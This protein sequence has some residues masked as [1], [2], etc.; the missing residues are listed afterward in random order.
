[1]TKKEMSWHSLALKDM[2]EKLDTDFKKGL[3]QTD[4]EGRLKKHGKNVFEQ[5]EKFYYWKLLWRQIRSPLVFILIIAGFV[6][7]FL[8]EITNTVVIFL[9]IFINVAIGIFQEGKASKA[10]EKIKGSQRKTTTVI[11]DGSQKIIEA[12]EVVPGDIIVLRMGDQ[13]PADARLLEDKGLEINESIITGEWAAVSK[14]SKKKA[15]EDARITKRENMVWMGTLVTEGW[16][17]AIVVETG[18]STEMG[19]IA[20]LVSGK[21]RPLTPL[22]K[23]IK[24]LAQFL[25]IVILATLA[26][27]FVLGILRGTPLSEM[28]LLSVAIAVAA[29]PEGLPVAVTVVLAMGMERILST[30]G[31]VKSLN[32][33][34][35]LGSTGIIITDKTGTLTMAEMQVSKIMSLMSVDKKYE[36]SEHKDRLHVLEKAVLASEA[37]IENPDDSLKE[38]KV[39]GRAVDAAILLAGVEASISPQEIFKKFPRI[40]LMPFDSER[41]FSASLNKNEKGKSCVYFLGAP[42]LVLDICNKVYV[43]GKN[44]KMS[45]KDMELLQQSYE[46]ETAEGIR[47]IGVAYKEGDW[48]SF[49]REGGHLE[50]E[51]FQDMVFAGF[52]G[53]HDPL[54]EDVV[55]AIESAKG[56]MIRPI[57]AT[58]DHLITAKKIA[59]EAGLL[60]EKGLAFDGAEVEKMKE[61]GLKKVVG[62][63]EIFARF[64]PHQKLDLVKMWQEKGEI[65][66]MTGDGVNDAPALKQANIG[67]ALGSGTEVAKEAADIILINNSFSI[68]VAAIEEGRRILDNLKK[69]IAYLLSTAF[70]EIIV[71]GASI[72]A[73]LP[74]PILPTQILW[75]NI[76]EEG[77]MNFAFAFEPK[78][79]DLMKRSPKHNTS[80][81]ILTKNLKKLIFTITAITGILL[82][83]LYFYLYNVGY[84]IDRLRTIMFAALSIDSIFFAF[85]LKN[86]KKPVWKIDIFSNKYLL[87]SLGLSILLLFG[88]LYIPILQTLLSLVTLSL[89]DVWL[90][91]QMG[92]LNLI[93]IEVSKYLFFEKGLLRKKK[94]ATI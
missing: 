91:I 20:A 1:M 19:K 7:L 32:A 65:V 86:L 17:M 2:K 74:L 27:M 51:M 89:A 72:I 79:K 64:L 31:L 14:T 60:S 11:R 43:A 87:F 59:K 66:A 88:A 15:R 5:E 73:G 46:K 33:A 76:I 78:E 29:I 45:K 55:E 38:W 41:R 42:E 16:A 9:A 34:E 90:V 93:T 4:I 61:E 82:I 22:Q 3:N 54:R 52:I 18:F 36:K 84:D 30:G 21:E 81:N 70:T 63:T 6:A 35:T 13:V 26:I 47:M 58:G 94:H 71:V 62:D 28:L 67:V 23:G 44:K 57:M 69:I 12:S 77:F 80:S 24:N 25:G 53:F 10:L 68:I 50:C 40:D 39:R 8:N 48:D 85:S 83:G 75:T 37:F 92:F 56:A 49:S